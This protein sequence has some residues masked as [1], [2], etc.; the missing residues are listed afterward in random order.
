MATGNERPVIPWTMAGGVGLPHVFQDG[1]CYPQDVA[2]HA[3]VL[4]D[5]GD[6]RHAKVHQDLRDVPH[7]D[8]Q[9]PGLGVAPDFG[10]LVGPSELNELHQLLM[11]VLV[12]ETPGLCLYQR[13]LTQV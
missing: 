6:G 11:V 10:L 5:P 2:R 7:Q 9:S 3:W 1:A 4:G 8:R 13:C 12:V